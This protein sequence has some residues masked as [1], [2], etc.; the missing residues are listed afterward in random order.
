MKSETTFI[1]ALA[2]PETG[3]TRYVGKADD[4]QRRY[5]R[6]KWRAVKNN[7]HKDCW[8]RG[9]KSRGLVPELKVL[10]EV[11]RVEWELWERAV[12]KAFRVLS[13]RLTN[14]TPGGECS[15]DNRGRK[16]SPEF[17]EKRIAPLRGRPRSPAVIAKVRA[18]NLGRPLTPEHREKLRIAKLGKKLSI[19]HREA[20]G[21]ALT[22]WKRTPEE[23]VVISERQRG[24]KKTPAH[25][26]AMRAGWAKRRAEKV[27][28]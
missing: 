11:P 14:Q 17:I 6:H 4:P 23:C 12:I 16:Q 26:A 5:L 8:I 9:L 27:G 15:P 7:A 28:K 13:V 21:A 1:Y 2:D 3:E 22:G 20:I 25:C 10:V 19:T 24:K 18:A